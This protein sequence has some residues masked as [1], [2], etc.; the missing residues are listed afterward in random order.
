M[1]FDKLFEQLIHQSEL[2]TPIN[3]PF[4][5]TEFELKVFKAFEDET[6]TV[7]SFC[8]DHECI[9]SEV[10]SVL[11]TATSIFSKFLFYGEANKEN[12][13]MRNVD[14]DELKR[15]IEVEF[16]HTKCPATAQRIALDHLAEIPDY[17]RRL[18]EMERVAGVI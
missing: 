10:L 11:R 5:F 4:N 3:S 8:N 14:P 13:K 15:G 9:P 2:E 1:K 7:E 17:Y 18:D 6:M 12:L 16:E